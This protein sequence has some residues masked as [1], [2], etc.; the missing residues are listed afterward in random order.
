MF[1]I[2][3][4]IILFFAFVICMGHVYAGIVVLSISTYLFKEVIELKRKETV[5]RNALFSFIEWY[6]FILFFY[7]LLPILF[8]R[9]DLLKS[10]IFEMTYTNG[11]P[12]INYYLETFLYKYHSGI[13]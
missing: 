9:R 5:F 6:F 12:S 4:L 8:L 7:L 1:F 10:S 2:K 13:F 3:A 11:R